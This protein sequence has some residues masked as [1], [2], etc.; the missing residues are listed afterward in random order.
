MIGHCRGKVFTTLDLM[1]GYHQ[2]KLRSESKDK[3]AFTCHLGLFQY[4][5]MPFGLTNTPATFQGL[6]NWLFSGTER[7]FVFVYLDDILTV[8]KSMEEHLKYMEQV[9]RCLEEIGL[10]LKL[11]KCAFAQTSIDYLGHTL[12]PKGVQPNDAKV[13]AVK[14]FPRPLSSIEVRQFL[15]IVNFYHRHVPNLASVAIS[16]TGLT[17]KGKDTGSLIGMI[18]VKL[19]SKR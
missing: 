4:K 2:I 11:Q 10:K 13:R 14:E 7:N 16:L 15:G 12:S 9:L 5:R 3:T 6:M 8:S 18:S 1:K 19:H 17:R